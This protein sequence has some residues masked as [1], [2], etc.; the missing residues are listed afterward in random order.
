MFVDFRVLFCPQNI[1]NHIAN[2]WL[3]NLP[4]HLVCHF[5]RWSKIPSRSRQSLLCLRVEA[6]VLNQTVYEHPHLVFYLERFDCDVFGLFLQ[7]RHY[8]I[9]DLV[10]Y[11]VYMRASFCRT[12][13]IHERNLLKLSLRLCHHH[14]PSFRYHGFVENQTFFILNIHHHVVLET[15]NWY[16]TSIQV[17]LN[18]EDSSHIIHSFFQEGCHLSG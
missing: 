2:P 9:D 15:F 17:H 1:Q 10:H 14:T 8:L 5:K 13:S 12:N 18:F 11:M 6:W 3:L 4:D 16:Q 7:N